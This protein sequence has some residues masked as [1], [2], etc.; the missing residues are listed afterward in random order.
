LNEEA[1]AQIA[2]AHA[3]W[4]E[5]LDE[6]EHVFEIVAGDAS[7]ERHF[8][9]SG[10]KK[11][12]VVDIAD[13]E[14]S[15][16]AVVRIQHLLIKL[17]HQVLLQ[18]LGGGDGIEKELAFFF[19]FMGPG[20]VAAGLRHVI[21]PFFVEFSQLIEFLLEL[22]IVRRGF[23]RGRIIGIGRELFQHRVGFHFLLHQV[24]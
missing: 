17:R 8:F 3:R 1:F 14:L 12:I 10:L 2:R 4:I 22:L 7:I 11:P 18:G 19:V 5:T 9:R 16:F 24:A 13:D 21:A 23:G 20:A 6:R 15:G